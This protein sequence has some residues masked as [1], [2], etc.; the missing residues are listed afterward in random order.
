LVKDTFR[1]HDRDRAP[2][3]LESGVVADLAVPDPEA[4]T[5][6]DL[7]PAHQIRWNGAT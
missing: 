2:A 1:S 3:E 7:A 5:L 6:A 4:I